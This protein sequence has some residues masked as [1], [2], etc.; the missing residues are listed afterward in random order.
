MSQGKDKK[1]N[2]QTKLSQRAKDLKIIELYFLLNPEPDR[3]LLRVWKLETANPA[4]WDE[5]LTTISLLIKEKLHDLESAIR[6]NEK[7]KM[8]LS[9]W[10][11]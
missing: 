1:V 4:D 5:I 11:K 9:R 2:S 8:I 10:Q 3:S 7:L 6:Q